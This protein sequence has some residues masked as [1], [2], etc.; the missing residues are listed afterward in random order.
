MKRAASAVGTDPHSCAAWRGTDAWVPGGLGDGC[1]DEGHVAGS[2]AGAKRGGGSA[3]LPQEAPRGGLFYQHPGPAVDRDV[4]LPAPA[5]RRAGAQRQCLFPLEKET[6]QVGIW[7]GPFTGLARGLAPLA[8]PAIAHPV[9]PLYAVVTGHAVVIAEERVT[10]HRAGGRVGGSCAHFLR[11]GDRLLLVSR[12]AAPGALLGVC[13][14]EQK[15][16]MACNALLWL[17]RPGTS[18]AEGTGPVP[19]QRAVHEVAGWHTSALVAYGLPAP[20]QRLAPT[21]QAG[22]AS[23]HWP[24][25]R[26]A[27]RATGG[28]G[29][30]RPEVLLAACTGCSSSV[31]LSGEEE[32]SQDNHQEEGAHPPS[33]EQPSGQPQPLLRLLGGPHG[34]VVGGGG[35][36]N[37]RL[38]DF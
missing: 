6:L 9:I 1:S 2:R 38:K 32:G 36:H 22:G 3:Q 31:K 5:Q 35:R 7:R 13:D 29:T 20:V 14:V 21:L 26:G 23:V 37:V 15:A 18:H 4:G 25:S 17:V 12:D 27:E 19:W 24:L 34:I 11:Q 28:G 10:V 33:Q 30:A 16:L 8:H